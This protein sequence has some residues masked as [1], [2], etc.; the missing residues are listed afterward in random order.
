LSFQPTGGLP[1]KLII[2]ISSLFTALIIKEPEHG[3]TDSIPL[4]TYFVTI[5]ARLSA[6]MG[7][8]EDGFMMI[9]LPTASAGATL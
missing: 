7:E 5:S 9:G 3:S 4:G 1:V 8:R 6:E 2:F